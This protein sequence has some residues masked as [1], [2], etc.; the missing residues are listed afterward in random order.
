MELSGTHTVAV[1]YNTVNALV[2]NMM[3]A[4]SGEGASI[5][6][7]VV[8]AM[9]MIARLSNDGLSQEDEVR[10]IQDISEYI[11]AYWGEQ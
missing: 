9:L 5:G 8:A 1:S 7:G 4:L 6:D 10:F 11:G 3:G 2:N